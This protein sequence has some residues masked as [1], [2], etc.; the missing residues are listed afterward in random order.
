MRLFIHLQN[1][2]R[3][4][5]QTGCQDV[6]FRSWRRA[7]AAALLICWLAGCGF[8]GWDYYYHPGHKIRMK[9]PKTWIVQE[10]I[11]NSVVAFSVP[12]K[13]DPKEFAFHENVS[14]VVQDVSDKLQTLELFTDSLQKH[15]K[16]IL[17]TAKITREGSEKVGKYPGQQIVYEV[18]GGGKT[19]KWWQVWTVHNHKA[20][21]IAS[22]SEEAKFDKF[23]KTAKQM[24][25][26]FEILE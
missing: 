2:V 13:K 23:Q 4:H 21:I 25:R 11:L 14:I 10:D 17:P 1:M 16:G 3:T 8:W 18:S 12:G 9:Y 7:G 20:Y 24:V 22:V 26:S 19:L 15:L 5:F 6:C